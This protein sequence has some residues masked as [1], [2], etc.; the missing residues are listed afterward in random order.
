MS[1]ERSVMGKLPYAS[2]GSGAPVVLLAGLSPVTGVASDGLVRGALGPLRPL[3]ARR[4]LIVFNRRPGLPTGMTIGE[5]ASEHADAFRA[6]LDG[7]VDLVGVSTGGSIAAQLAA[8]HPDVVS[9]LV[10]ISAACRLGAYGRQVQT[11]VAADLRAGQTRRALGLVGYALAPRGFRAGGRLLGRRAAS[12]VI[13]TAGAAEDIAVTLEAEDGFDLAECEN[14]I[15]AKTLIIAGGRDR[16]YAPQLFDQTAGLIPDSD[17][18]VYEKRGHLGVL[19]EQQAMSAI[20]A[21]LSRT[22]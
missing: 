1:I 12:T 3:A 21:F 14:R 10:L 6:G 11:Q 13:K 8:D 7:P 20:A 2:A 4:R 22:G 19:R 9:R 5:L 18:R 17:L 15:E 16:F